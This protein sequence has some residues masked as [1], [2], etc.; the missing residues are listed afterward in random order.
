[1]SEKKIVSQLWALRCQFGEQSLRSQ[2][3][4]RYEIRK[5]SSGFLDCISELAVINLD[6]DFTVQ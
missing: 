5:D 3:L 1:M 2:W 4:S 6:K